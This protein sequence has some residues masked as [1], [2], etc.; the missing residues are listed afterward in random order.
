MTIILIQMIPT[1]E[2]ILK[3]IE[4]EYKNYNVIIIKII[5]I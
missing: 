4:S 1:K 5:L 2:S 3:C